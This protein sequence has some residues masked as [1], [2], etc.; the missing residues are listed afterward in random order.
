[1][2][3][4]ECALNKAEMMLTVLFVEFHEEMLLRM[5]LKQNESKNKKLGPSPHCGQSFGIF[6]YIS[7]MSGGLARSTLFC[8]MQPVK[9]I[10]SAGTVGWLMW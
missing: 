9:A 1:M 6:S 10:F 3:Q 8:L 4:R 5:N 2:Y 7:Q